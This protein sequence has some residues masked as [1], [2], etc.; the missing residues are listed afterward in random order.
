MRA[1][2]MAL[3]CLLAAAAVPAAAQQIDRYTE[4]V[5]IAPSGDAAVTIDLDLPAGFA[6]AMTIA[7]GTGR[8]S[9]IDTATL[10]LADGQ[11]ARASLDARI[12][13]DGR[14]DIQL[15]GAADARTRLHLIAHVRGAVDMSTAPLAHGGR[16][17]RYRLAIPA[18]LDVRRVEATVILPSD[19]VVGNVDDLSP[20]PADTAALPAYRTGA[21]DGRASVTLAVAPHGD[22]AVGMTVHARRQ[23]NG[24][25]VA[26]VLAII[27]GAYLW[28][29]RDLI[30][31]P[32]AAVRTP[33]STQP[34]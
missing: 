9:T 30:R 6:G 24:P 16:D 3:G 19:L 5:D 4:T 17:V 20:A 1:A 27:A 22:G 14:V 29:F 15:S 2:A 25:A 31:V 26:A 13:S 23:P 10:L 7:S 28:F 21:R 8:M 33:S 18:T 32:P 11:R 34:S 12:A